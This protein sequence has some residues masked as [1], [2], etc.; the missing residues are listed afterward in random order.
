MKNNDLWF[1]DFMIDHQW[2]WAS[3]TWWSIKWNIKNHKSLVRGTWNAFSGSVESWNSLI[4]V[5]SSSLSL[6][7]SLSRHIQ[8]PNSTQWVL[9]C[10]IFKALSVQ[11]L[12]E[13]LTFVLCA[14]YI[15]RIYIYSSLEQPSGSERE[16]GGGK[17]RRPTRTEGGERERSISRKI[18]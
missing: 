11:R 12:L 14:I 9:C 1:R 10:F 16:C 4:F 3:W 6:L 8:Q 17:M 18:H 5:L 7:L 15:I 13:I 2:G